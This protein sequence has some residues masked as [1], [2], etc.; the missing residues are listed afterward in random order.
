M[1]DFLT[2]LATLYGCEA[3]LDT[4]PVDHDTVLR[5]AV[6]QETVTAAFL[7]DREILALRDIALRRGPTMQLAYRRFREWEID[8]ADLVE[9]FREEARSVV[10]TMK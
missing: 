4:Q 3:L 5:C 7:T 8:N 9:V 1:N 6:A 2:V 10:T